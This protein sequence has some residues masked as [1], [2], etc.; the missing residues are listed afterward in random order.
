[1]IYLS[2]FGDDIKLITDYLNR[3]GVYPS[4]AKE[5]HDLYSIFSEECYS[6]GWMYIDEDILEKFTAWTIDFCGRYQMYS[7]EL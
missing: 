3:N 7:E 6:A 4:D 2:K 1:M 5:V